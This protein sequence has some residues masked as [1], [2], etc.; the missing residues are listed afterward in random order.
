MF[1]RKVGVKNSQN[2]QENPCVAAYSLQLY[3]KR[4]SSITAFLQNT[5]GILSQYQMIF[6][7]Y[8]YYILLKFLLTLVFSTNFLLAIQSQ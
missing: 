1:Y 8:P 2:S 7:H 5:Y 3:L 6:I 4:N